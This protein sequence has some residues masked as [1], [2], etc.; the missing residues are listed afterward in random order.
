MLYKT[1]GSLPALSQM[2]AGLGHPHPTTI[3]R[4]L[5]VD[6]RTVYRWQAADQAPRPAA[7]ALFWLTPWGLSLIDS[8]LAFSAAN[9]RQL[10]DA[11]ARDL[12]HLAAENQRLQAMAE[13]HA[14]HGRAANDQAP[15]SAAVNTRAIS[16][17]PTSMVTVAPGSAHA[18]T[19]STMCSWSGLAQVAGSANG[20]ASN[21]PS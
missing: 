14:R 16:A 1:P 17:A 5:G 6:V 18:R 20:S 13:H 9:A 2:L 12:Q 3:A 11:R 8:D 7:L 10:A 19:S 21:T 4:V 15:N